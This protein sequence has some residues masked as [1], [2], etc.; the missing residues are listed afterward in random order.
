[1]SYGLTESSEQPK[2]FLCCPMALSEKSAIWEERIICDDLAS[3]SDSIW[4]KLL[5]T[6]KINLTL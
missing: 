4:I 1:M 2:S 5:K 6:L 3:D